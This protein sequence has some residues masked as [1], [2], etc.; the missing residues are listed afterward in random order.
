MNATSIAQSAF[1]DKLPDNPLV[2]F[3]EWWQEARLQGVTEPNA[4]IVASVDA[5]GMP[6]TR[7]VYLRDLVD[8]GFVFYTNYNSNKS[9][10][11]LTTPKVALNFFWAEL[12]RQVRICGT[13]EKVPAEMSDAYFAARARESQLGAWASPQSQSIPSREWLMNEVERMSQRF[14]GAEVPRPP[15]WGGFLIRPVSIEFWNGRTARLHDRMRYLKS[16]ESWEVS[17]LAP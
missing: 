3:Q 15:H 6:H 13:P 12:D 7:I 4:M 14:E 5:E 2:L 17:R 10:Q 16:D 8:E 11:L 9:Q 1:P